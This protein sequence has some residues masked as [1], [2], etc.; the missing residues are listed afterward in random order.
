MG[1]LTIPECCDGPRILEVSSLNLRMG[2]RE[3]RRIKENI[4]FSCSL[5][6]HTFF[7][8]KGASALSRITYELR[9]TEKHLVLCGMCM[10]VLADALQTGPSV[11]E[12]SDWKLTSSVARVSMVE[13]EILCANCW[14]K[15]TTHLFMKFDNLLIGGKSEVYRT[16]RACA[17]CVVSY[18]EMMQNMNCM[19]RKFEYVSDEDIV[20]YPYGRRILVTG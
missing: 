5:C 19:A 10:D 12:R 6:K 2:R 20:V 7:L 14:N 9:K 13:E 11:I 17:K 18:I 1:Q 8:G 4:K 16:R 3:T 15:D